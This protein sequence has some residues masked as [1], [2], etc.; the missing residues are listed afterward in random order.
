MAFRRP[1]RGRDR[2]QHRDLADRFQ[3]LGRGDVL[4]LS[5]GS[6]LLNNAFFCTLAYLLG[7]GSRWLWAHS[8][9]A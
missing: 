6:S 4:V 3:R 2:G 7:V 8:A 5:I 1:D 9:T